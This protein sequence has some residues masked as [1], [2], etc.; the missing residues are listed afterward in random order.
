MSWNGSAE[1]MFGRSEGQMVGQPVF[2]IAAPGYEAEMRD[3]LRRI[4]EGEKIDHYET[5]RRHADGSI[6]NISL[7]VSPIYDV[8]GRLV[9]ASKVA[10]DVTRATRSET[11]LKQSQTRLQ[12][13]QSEL[14]HVSR[15]SAMGEMASALAHEVNQPLAAISNYMKGSRRLL[16][17]I[18][19]PVAPKIEEAMDKASE[20]AIR[21]GQI[22]RRLRDFVVRGESEKRPRA[23]RSSS[24]TLSLWAWWRHA[25]AT[26]W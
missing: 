3:I 19:D 14:L 12:E 23:W 17:G 15:L 2:R 4:R 25:N 8:S 1:R 21:A 18:R 24:K 6:V 16:A 20:Q 9:G 10:R 26:S 11:A 5:L 7:S 22:I 13:L